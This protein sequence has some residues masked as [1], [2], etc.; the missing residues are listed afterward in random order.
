MNRHE[1]F[2]KCPKC[3]EEKFH[4]FAWDDIGSYE[5]PPDGGFEVSQECDC[6]ISEEEMDSYID[7]LIEMDGILD[8]IG[9]Y[10]MEMVNLQSNMSGIEA[11]AEFSKEELENMVIFH[12]SIPERIGKEEKKYKDLMKQLY[13]KEYKERFE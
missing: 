1:T 6:E 7:L 8:N 11:E 12:D 5:Q 2:V 3:F 4:I 9:Y 10:E 13:G